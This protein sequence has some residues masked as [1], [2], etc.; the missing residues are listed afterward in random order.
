LSK[1]SAVGF[2]TQNIPPYSHTDSVAIL[3]L[4]NVFT[5]LIFMFFYVKQR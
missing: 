3:N 4:Y 2:S 1:K 5:R